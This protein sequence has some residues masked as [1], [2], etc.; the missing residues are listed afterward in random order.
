[1]EFKKAEEIYVDEALMLAL[2]EYKAE[3]SKVKQLPAID[4]TDQLKELSVMVLI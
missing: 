4:F 2:D 3:C 1:M